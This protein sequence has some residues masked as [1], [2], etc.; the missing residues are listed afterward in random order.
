[1]NYKKVQKGEDLSI[2][3]AVWNDLLNLLAQS[4]GNSGRPRQAVQQRQMNSGVVMARNIS[5][6]PLNEFRAVK[7]VGPT[8]LPADS[9]TSFK[10]RVVLDVTTPDDSSTGLW[11]VLQESLAAGAEGDEE[12]GAFGEAVVSGITV[13]RV[14]INDAS[15]TNVEV[16]DGETVLSSS[17]SGSGQIVWVA[18][19]VGTADATGEQWAL[20]RLPTGG[21]GTSELPHGQYLGTFYGTVASNTSAWT[22]PFLHEV[23]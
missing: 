19:G 16:V 4:K 14:D 23:F 1:M 10:N 21:S 11:C 2:S 17:E 6:E 7:I 13:A 15:D 18:G 8:V 5:G 22:F 9:E 20:V 12:N 3:A